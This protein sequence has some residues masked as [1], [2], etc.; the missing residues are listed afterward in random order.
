MPK[1]PKRATLPNKPIGPEGHLVL[2]LNIVSHEGILS[3]LHLAGRRYKLKSLNSSPSNWETI[4]AIFKEHKVAAVIGKLYESV[5]LKIV[6]PEYLRIGKR[7]FKEIGGV[8]NLIFIY[9]AS[10]VSTTCRGVDGIEYVVTSLVDS[11]ESHAEAIKL[12]HDNGVNIS[13][14]DSRAEVTVLSESF[15]ERLDKNLLLRLYVPL[16]RLWTDEVDKLLQLFQEYLTKVD[17]LAIRLDRKRTDCGG[18]YEFHGEARTG[19]FT[20]ATEFKDFTSFIGLCACDLKAAENVLKLKD[21][22]TRDVSLILERY[23]KEVRRLQLDIKHAAESKIVSIRHRLEAE[24]VESAPT[25]HEWEA[26]TCVINSFIPNYA[27]GSPSLVLYSDLERPT[28]VMMCNCRPQLISTV[29]EIASEEIHGN[30]R[31]TE[32]DK[33]I[34]DLIH[35]HGDDKAQDLETAMHE[36]ADKGVDSKDRLSAMR[37]VKTFLTILGTR[38]GDMAFSILQK[39]I[40]HRIGI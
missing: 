34:L 4:E 40:E 7:L 35:K 28:G 20:L 15:L 30:Q 31:F 10:S 14:Y 26:M 17:R 32:E 6:D 2:L 5:L 27:A 33:Q 18:I 21:L 16:G 23:S 13:L 12:L 29:N 3:A 25:Q 9:P 38:T 1:T 39:Y 24:L 36:I 11:L 8:R 19:E 22:G 37:R